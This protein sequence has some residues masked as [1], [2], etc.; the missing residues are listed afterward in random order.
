MTTDKEELGF[1]KNLTTRVW[2]S[3]GT[4][5]GTADLS[6][7]LC[8]VCNL[9]FLCPHPVN[10]TA[11]ET[12]P[13]TWP[14]RTA[15]SELPVPL[16]AGG[17]PLLNATWERL[18]GPVLYLFSS[19]LGNLICLVLSG[20]LPCEIQ[21]FWASNS[22]SQRLQDTCSTAEQRKL[23]PHLIFCVYIFILMLSYIS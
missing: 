17:V 18:E 23:P 16:Q 4:G 5:P 11:H 7:Q 10:R 8:P 19:A 13:G 15:C 12:V 9:A 21:P 1:Y 14:F 2:C 6:G 3:E 20:V 22:E